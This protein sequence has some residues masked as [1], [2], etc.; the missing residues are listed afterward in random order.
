[1][2]Q[3]R[4]VQPQDLEYI[5]SNAESLGYKQD[6]MYD[7][8]ENMMVV[9]DNSKITGIGFYINKENKCI[10]NWIY[11]MK[12]YRRDRLGTM[13]V[14]TMLNIAEQ[15]GALQAY[16]SG[17]Y[18]DFAEFLGFEKIQDAGEIDAIN[19]LYKD[20]YKANRYET[21]YKVSLI[22]YFKPCCAK[23]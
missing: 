19:Q 1:M 20:F 13:L 9:I 6:F 3:V 5:F 14:K 12:D 7:F 21:I 2:I 16:I 18:E 15:Q 8:L 17:E 11:I 23:K 10:L 4:R 22:D